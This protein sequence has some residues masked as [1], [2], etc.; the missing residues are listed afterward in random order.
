MRNQLTE[1]THDL[2]K[3]IHRIDF[4]DPDQYCWWLSQAYYFVRHSTPMLALS[5]GL[6][7]EHPSYHRRCIEHLAEEK[8]HDQ[9]LLNDLKA[10]GKTIQ[11]Y[12]ELAGTQAFYQTQYYWI[13]H[14]S[15]LSFLGYIAILEGSS[16]FAG[17][18]VLEKVRHHRGHS[19]L[20]VHAEDDVSHLEKAFKAIESLPEREQQLI[21]TNARMAVDLYDMMVSQILER[22]T[23]PRE[24]RKAS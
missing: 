13:E 7:V 6:A 16:V 11:Q 1:C 23:A 15:P 3:T 5:A 12:P 14:K 22:A 17:K 8:G 24:A 2:V 21:V 4:A 18:P 9:M 10:M 19:F 20:R